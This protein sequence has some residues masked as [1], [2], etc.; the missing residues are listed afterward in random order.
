MKTPSKLTLALIAATLLALLVV[1]LQTCHK[2]KDERDEWKQRAQIQ[3]RQL[4]SLRFEASQNCDS[5][6]QKLIYEKG[7]RADR[8]AWLRNNR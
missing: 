5:I 2:R 6:I 7:T 8:P 1:S 4:D 3:Q